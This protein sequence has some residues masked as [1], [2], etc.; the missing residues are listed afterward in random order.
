MSFL[1]SN[2]TLSIYR[3]GERIQT[4]RL[5][6][7]SA[8]TSLHIQFETSPLI[9]PRIGS[10]IFRAVL[11][12]ADGGQHAW[13]ARVFH[14]ACLTTHRSL[15]PSLV[16]MRRFDWRLFGDMGTLLRAH[17]EWQS[18][19]IAAGDGAGSRYLVF[20]PDENGIGNRF[21]AL[22]RL[23]CPCARA[24]AERISAEPVVA[25]SAVPF[26]AKVQRS[27]AFVHT[28]AH[29]GR[30]VLTGGSQQPRIFS[31]VGIASVFVGRFSL[32][33]A[34]HI[35]SRA[36]HFFMAPRSRCRVGRGTQTLQQLL[37]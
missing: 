8:G 30:L 34:T 27:R 32:R 9:F 37:C 24:S 29:A 23:L 28:Q 21:M 17:R 35:H 15:S 10:W 13:A 1:G 4:F 14:A 20:E 12:D 7:R 19:L 31:S 26:E 11:L 6:S 18:E 22:V 16:P 36:R 3:N 25:C 2:A 33:S 5:Y